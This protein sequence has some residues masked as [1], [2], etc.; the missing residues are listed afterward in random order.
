M[1]IADTGERG[2]RLGYLVQ[3]LFS[4]ANGL[5]YAFWDTG[6]DGGTARLIASGKS[7]F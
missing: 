4:N 1:V 2:M 3:P 7:P 5:D 6:G